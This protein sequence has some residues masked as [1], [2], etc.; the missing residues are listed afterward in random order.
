MAA[1]IAVRADVAIRW[2][3]S[4]RFENQIR[5]GLAAGGESIRT[6]CSARDK[7]RFRG[8]GRV[9]ADRPSARAV[10]SEQSSASANQ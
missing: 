2:I 8:F 7:Q 10:S 9:E 4:L 5:I 1:G 3:A 6:S